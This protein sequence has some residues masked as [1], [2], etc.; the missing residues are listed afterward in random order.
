[1]PD[2][3]PTANQITAELLIR[4]PKEFPGS[5]SWRNNTGAVK[6]DNRFIRFNLKGAPDILAV[7]RGTL[8]GLE[9]KGPGDKQSVEQESWAHALNTAGGKYLLIE[10]IIWDSGKPAIGKVLEELKAIVNT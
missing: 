9:I 10:K 2:K 7:I 6:L 4:L 3:P 8:F 1:M 5:F